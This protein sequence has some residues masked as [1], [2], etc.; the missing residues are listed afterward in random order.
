ML[1]RPTTFRGVVTSSTEPDRRRLYRLS[2]KSVVPN[3][4]PFLGS[5]LSVY[6]PALPRFRNQTGPE[7]VSAIDAS[8]SSQGVRMPK[9]SRTGDDTKAFPGVS[10]TS[11]LRS[12]SLEDSTGR[13][14]EER[15]YTDYECIG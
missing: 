15:E 7:I 9:V 14:K 13:R 5:P 3:F 8:S 12:H 10:A 6:V 1:G 11:R 4:A 2:R